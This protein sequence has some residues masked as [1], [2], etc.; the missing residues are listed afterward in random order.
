V[1]TS[2]LRVK[3]QH[4]LYCM[5]EYITCKTSTADLKLIDNLNVSPD[6]LT[7]SV[8]TLLTDL[9]IDIEACGLKQRLIVC[10]FA[11]AE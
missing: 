10:M 5:Y 1:G 8:A 7:P 2:K 4:I 9:T 3:Y 6:I 11:V